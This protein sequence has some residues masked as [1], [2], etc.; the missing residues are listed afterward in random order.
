[1][2]DEIQRVRVEEVQ[3][4]GVLGFTRLFDSFQ[5]AIRP[6]QLALAL[7]LIAALWVGGHTMDLLCGPNA[8]PNEVTQYASLTTDEFNQWMDRLDTSDAPQAGVYITAQRFKLDAVNR[9][10]TAAARLHFGFDELLGPG[11]HNRHSVIGS[12]HDMMVTLPGWLYHYHK[13]FFLFYCLGALGIWALLGGAIARMSALHATRGKRLSILESIGFAKSQWVWFVL[14]PMIPLALA[15][16]I[17]LVPAI[18]GLILFNP[19]VLN[20][21]GGLVFPLLLICGAVV[22]VMLV[23]LA[24]G[25]PMLYPAI[26]VEKTDA[27]D[28]IS[29]AFGYILNRPW[30]W[31]FYNLITFVYG[32]LTYLLVS[33][34]LFLTLWIT[35]RCVGL[36]VFTETTEGLNRFESIFPTPVL[37]HLAGGVGWSGLS[38]FDKTAAGLILF[39]VY[40]TLL[41]LGAYAGG[42]FPMAESRDDPGVFW[43][44]PHVRVGAVARVCARLSRFRVRWSCIPSINLA[45]KNRRKNICPNLQQV[46][47]S[48]LTH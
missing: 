45:L 25:G 38:V 47:I 1:M 11:H 7:L 12:L 15:G 20:I 22:T 48:G 46:S 27:F 28:A 32:A 6:A 29:R 40:F 8:Y 33:M 37:S 21:A 14:A 34:V 35:H 3:W 19:P 13:G 31:L 42:I 5:M 4:S 9:L 23:L 30:R 43:V 26:A 44:D 2:T 10:V 39:W 41:L 16:M 18:S 24:A 17:A 36:W